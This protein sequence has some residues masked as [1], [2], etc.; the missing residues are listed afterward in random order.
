MKENLQ[1]GKHNVATIFYLNERKLYCT[2]EREL[3]LNNDYVAIMVT[4]DDFA[5]DSEKWE[6]KEHH[7]DMNGEFTFLKDEEDYLTNEE[8]NDIK[9]FIVDYFNTNY[10]ISRLLES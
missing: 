9:A 6:I 4:Y 2:F 7:Y 3:T 10:D 8:R 1:V 5:N